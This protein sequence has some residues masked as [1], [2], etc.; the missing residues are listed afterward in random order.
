MYLRGESDRGMVKEKELH[1]KFFSF[2]TN[3]EI[4]KFEESMEVRNS[5]LHA[6]RH[7]RK[8]KLANE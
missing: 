6:N 3:C 7:E 4:V 2:T 8:Y 5:L 1:F